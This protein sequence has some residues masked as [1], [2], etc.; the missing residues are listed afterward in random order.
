MRHG[1]S[2]ALWWAHHPLHLSDNAIVANAND[3][4]E[5]LVPGRADVALL[6]MPMP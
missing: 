6:R 4:E 1:E 5:P 3:A 2:E